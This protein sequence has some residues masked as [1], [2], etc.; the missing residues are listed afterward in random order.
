MLSVTDEIE[1]RQ[2]LMYACGLTDVG[3]RRL[4]NEDYLFCSSKPVGNLPNLFLVADGMGGHQG[5]EY[6]SRRAVEILLKLIRE[7]DSMD[8]IVIL[9]DCIEE[10]NARL[11]KEAQHDTGLQ[12]MGTTMVAATC[13]GDTLAVA[14]VGDSRLY[15]WGDEIRQ[16]TRDHSLVEEMV[17]EGRMKRGSLEYQMKKNIITRAIAVDE[18]VTPDFFECRL[19]GENILLCSDGL[20]NMLTDEEIRRIVT[21]EGPLED[22]AQSLIDAANQAGGRDNITVVLIER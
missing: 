8:P 2:C 13:K 1:R 15:L 21:R 9:K 3:Q 12:G 20:T 5:G 17:S 11:W 16:V 10:M 19:Q 6:A 14:N 22:R 7:D 4:G 18:S